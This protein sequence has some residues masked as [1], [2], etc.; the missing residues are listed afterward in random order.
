M[1]HDL[2]RREFAKNV[3]RW[4]L[5]LF[6][7]PV[8]DKIRCVEHGLVNASET[9]TEVN[10]VEVVETG[11]RFGPSFYQ[12]MAQQSKMIV[13]WESRLLREYLRPSRWTAF[14]GKD[15]HSPIRL[16]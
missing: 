12:V 5:A 15:D 7:L 1:T 13:D 14:M 16:L 8:A 3:G 4:A 10:I 11:R 2:S 9:A 6:M